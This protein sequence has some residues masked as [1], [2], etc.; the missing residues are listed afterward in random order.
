LEQKDVRKEVSVLRGLIL[1]VF[2]C[3]KSVTFLV[4]IQQ[5][6]HKF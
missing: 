5:M 4:I 1:Q 6:E 3:T 2:A